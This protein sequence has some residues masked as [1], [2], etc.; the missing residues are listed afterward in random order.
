MKIQITENINQLSSTQWNALVKDNMPFLRFEFLSALETHQC[1]GEAYGWIPQHFTMFDDKNNLIGAMPMYLKTNSYGEFV[2]DQAWADAYARSGF[3]YYPKLVSCTP[4]TPANANRILVDPEYDYQHIASHF[5]QAAIQHTQTLNISSAH[6]LFPDQQQQPVLE[7]FEFTSRIDCQFHWTNQQ[8]DSFDHY[9]SFMNTRKRKK[10]KRERRFVQQADIDIDI[11]PSDQASEEQ[12]HQC[13]Q[14][15]LSTFEKKWG[16][17]TLSENFFNAIAETMGSQML[18]VF[19]KHQN[20][21]V[22]AAVDFKSDTTLY[23]RH[24]GCNEEFH[25]L[26]F[27]LCYYQGLEYCIQHKLKCFEPGAQGEHKISRG[28]LPKK[29]R[30]FHWIQHPE[31]RKIIHNHVEHETTMMLEYIEELASTSPFKTIQ[32]GTKS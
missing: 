15:Y 8:Y 25:S 32:S 30:S 10:I 3:Q 29:T 22:A 24:W 6:W 2:F 1:L 28:F 12:I 23:G 17:A 26:H 20:N 13:H 19:A 21:Y 31:F 18:L 4:Y 9:L 11:I 27:E 5:I 14:F 16:Q 7:N